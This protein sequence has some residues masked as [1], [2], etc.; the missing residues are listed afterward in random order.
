MPHTRVLPDSRR[1]PAVSEWGRQGVRKTELCLQN[2]SVM[3]IV[4]NI[5]LFKTIV[6][7]VTSYLKCTKYSYMSIIKMYGELKRR[8][9]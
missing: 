1:S 3:L 8:N 2:F 5:E 6:S 7:I 9:V 4:K